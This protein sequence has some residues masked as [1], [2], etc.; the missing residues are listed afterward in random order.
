MEQVNPTRMEL[1]KKR[2]QIRLAEQGRDLLREKMD[3]LIREFFRIM[4]NVSDSRGK[5]EAVA[6]SA[7]RSLLI[8]EAVDDP[9]TLK[10]ASFATKRRISLDI[11]GKNIMGV[12]VPII[13]KKR[14]TLTI[15]ER[16]YSPIGISGR[17]DETAE[18]FETE[19][20]LIIALAETETALRRIG[21]EIQMNRRRVNALEQVLIPELKQQAKYIKIT[22][23]EREREDLYRLK[24]V[25]RLLQKKKQKGSE[26]S[27]Q[28]QD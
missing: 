22:I 27:P 14:F 9:V 16:G 18:R 7:Q 23:E 17:I 1:I 2:A 8:A 6:D 13:E 3:A 11:R 15:T 12:P 21:E 20:D 26:V 10:S 19:L 25:K 28:E 4:T 5:L 24:K